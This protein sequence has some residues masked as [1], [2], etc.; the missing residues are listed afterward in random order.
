MRKKRML[1]LKRIINILKQHKDELRKK[2]YVKE[3]G[4]FGSYVRGEHQKK[5]DVDILVELEENAD[6]DLIMFVNMENYLRELLGVRVDLV[7]KSV[8]KPRIG[9]HI[10]REVMTI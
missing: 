1:T 8:L 5:S 3:I 7:E 4:I 6:I 9:K 2:Y 10:L